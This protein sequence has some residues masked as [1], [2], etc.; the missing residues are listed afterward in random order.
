V[1]IHPLAPFARGN[2]PVRCRRA[3]AAGKTSM[4]LPPVFSPVIPRAGFG[5]RRCDQMNRRTHLLACAWSRPV[6]FAVP[7]GQRF[8]RCSTPTAGRHS[9]PHGDVSASNC[10]WGEIRFRA[11]LPAHCARRESRLINALIRRTPRLRPGAAAP[12][13]SGRKPLG[14]PICPGGQQPDWPWARPSD[15][16]KFSVSSPRSSTS[17]APRGRPRHFDL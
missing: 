15:E 9:P 13:A 12:H 6:R 5:F 2:C 7:V 16:V 1:S 17:T 14:K 11:S 10:V 8:A 3:F 4:G